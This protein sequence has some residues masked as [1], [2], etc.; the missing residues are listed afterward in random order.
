MHLNHLKPFKT[1]EELCYA[2]EDEDDDDPGLDDPDVPDLDAED[3]VGPSQDPDVEDV[4]ADADPAD[5]AQDTDVEDVDAD[6][7][8]A[9]VRAD[10]IGGLDADDVTPELFSSAALGPD[11]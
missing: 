9:G 7:P 8:T 4:D 5:P 1:S 6:G 2:S 11:V 3:S 10:F